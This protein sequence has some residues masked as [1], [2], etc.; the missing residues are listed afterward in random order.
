[1]QLYDYPGMMCNPGYRLPVS[2]P[3]GHLGTVNAASAIQHHT[4]AA[5]PQ[6]NSAQAAAAAAQLAP[7]TPLVLAQRGVPQR[8]R[9]CCPCHNFTFN[10]NK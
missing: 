7:T 5:P 6:L 3:F 2:W 4:P 10:K 8:R 1:M 9:Y